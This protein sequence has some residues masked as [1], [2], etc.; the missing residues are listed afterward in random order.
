MKKNIEKSLSAVLIISIMLIVGLVGLGV[1]LR[2]DKSSPR[3]QTFSDARITSGWPTQASPP[4]DF[5][6]TG[7]NDNIPFAAAVAALPSGGLIQIVGIPLGPISFAGSVTLPNQP[8]VIL[9]TGSSSI[10]NYDAAHPIF[11]VTGPSA[12]VF[13]D[14]ATD[15]GGI[16]GAFQ[17]LQNVT[18]GATYY[19]HY[20][21]SGTLT[22]SSVNT[23][24]IV[25][26]G[27]IAGATANI[28]TTNSTNL[29][30]TNLTA[31]T[32]RSAT[33]LVAAYDASPNEI[34][35]ADC[36]VDGV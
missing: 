35:Q 8:F 12:V 2:F 5:T 13:R 4:P 34:K 32:G 26:S 22:S 28:I 6:F 36:V 31:P 18:L 21:A 1:G 14:L 20:F 10:F 3:L 30:S 16:T 27:N 23:G 29:V 15:A 33:F 25:A 24:G 9:G 17:E 11:I 7:A 19:A